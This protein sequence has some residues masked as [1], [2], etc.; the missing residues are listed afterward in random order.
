MTHREREMVSDRGTSERKGA[1]SLKCPASSEQLASSFSVLC[2]S[3]MSNEIDC[4]LPC[5]QTGPEARD[6]SAQNAV[7]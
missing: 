4:Y 2:S 7:S 5:T 6:D 3:V 1:L